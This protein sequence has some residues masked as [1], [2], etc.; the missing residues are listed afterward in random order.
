MNGLTLRSATPQD[1]AFVERIYFE[2][3]R[4]LIERL[5]GWRGDDI[6]HAKFDEVYDEQHT[7]IVQIDGEEVGWL[8]VLRE[9]DRIEV[10]SIYIASERRGA[11]IGTHLME[12]LIVEAE[13]TRK[14]L[15]L[16]TAKMNPAR[17]LYER[18]GFEAVDE[19]E[20]KV[21]MERKARKLR[22]SPLESVLTIRHAQSTD[23]D[24][25][26]ALFDEVAAERRWIGTEPGFD[27]AKYRDAWRAIVDGKGGA[28]F[29]ASH[30]NQVVGALS[31]LPTS[32]GDHDLGILVSQERRG[33][34]VG[35]ALM[36]EAFAWAQ[37]HGVPK[38]TLGVFPHNEIA[39]S[40][41]E[42]LGFV[43]VRRLERKRM[44]QTGE[45]WDIIVMEKQMFSGPASESADP[46]TLEPY[47]TR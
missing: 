3:Q 40:L 17:R 42:K 31:L 46:V 13:L 20:F 26:L 39:R 37:T 5:F 44:R 23:F 1:R 11:G 7:K 16:S 29:V 2:T 6:E 14:T 47:D 38:L 12:Q 32:G 41:Y 43:V 36:R 19:G 35:T 9:T 18:L 30:G 33:E 21:Y 34:G 27:K 4:W 25:L 15:T 28:H 24:Q 22:A 8:T 10:E 45:A